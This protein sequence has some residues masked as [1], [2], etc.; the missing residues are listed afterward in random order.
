MTRFY[1]TVD[2]Y[3]SIKRKSA[4][5]F[6]PLSGSGLICGQPFAAGECWLIHKSFELENIAGAEFIM[7]SP[8]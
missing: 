7:A 3:G 6:I 4:A 8:A 5:W 2:M 1:G